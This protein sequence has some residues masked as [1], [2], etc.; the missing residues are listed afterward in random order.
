MLPWTR[1]S[2]LSRVYWPGLHM[3]SRSSVW[4][5]WEMIAALSVITMVSFRIKMIMY[6]VCQ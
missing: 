5:V 1:G 2:R 6:G 4:L 3:D